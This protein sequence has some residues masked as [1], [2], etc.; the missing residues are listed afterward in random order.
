[1]REHAVPYRLGEL[2]GLRYGPL[3]ESLEAAL[4]RWLAERRVAEGEEIH[5]GRVWHWEELAI[6]L[7]PPRGELREWFRR[8]PAVRAAELHARLS[9]RTPRPLVAVQERRGL[10]L[11]WSLFASE[12]VEGTFLPRTWDSDPA[13]REAFPRF[14]AAM[15]AAGV[16]HGDLHVRNML[17]NGREWVLLDLESLRHPLRALRRRRIIEDQWARLVCSLGPREGVQASFEAYLREVGAKWEPQ[18]AWRRVEQ[19]ARALAPEW[20][21]RAG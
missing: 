9:V 12:F 21:P 10:A 7:H 18:E 13:G 2:R 8:S 20:A 16:F 15:H 4:P 17:W 6:K 14:L 3:P 19:R 1:M 5:P 11:G